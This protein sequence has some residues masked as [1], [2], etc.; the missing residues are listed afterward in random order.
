MQRN[1]F[2]PSPIFREGYQK[3]GVTM[4][5]CVTRLP[6]GTPGHT[7]FSEIQDYDLL[8]LQKL[9]HR[10]MSLVLSLLVSYCEERE[11]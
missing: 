4:L 11:R 2:P 1:L 9:L 10:Y 8:Y 5:K 3:L 6:A 7:P